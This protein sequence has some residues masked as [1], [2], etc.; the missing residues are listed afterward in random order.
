MSA[1]PE[2]AAATADPP[3]DLPAVT[4]PP[5]R[6]AGGHLAAVDVVRFLTIAGV[7]LVH[8]TSFAN[9]TTSVAA[10]GVLEV[11][12]ITR[13]V[14]LMLSAFVLSY[15][16]S[17]RPLP[18]RAFWR[19]RYPLIAIPYVV[20]SAIYFLTDGGVHASL[21]VVGTFFQDLLDGGAKFHLYFL[22]LTFQLY[23]IF[24]ALMAAFRRWPRALIPTLWASLAF[25][26]L[27][28]A[29][30][31][32]GWRPPILGVWLAHPGSWLPSY[33]MYVVGGVAA[34]R[35][36]DGLTAW[37]RGHYRILAAGFAAAVGLSVASYLLDQSFLGY[38]P[39][40]A[41]EV[42]QPANVLEA[43]AA[44][45]AEFAL[46]LWVAD[47]ASARRLA[48]LERASDVSFGLYLAHP[49]LLGAVLDVAGWV[50]LSAAMSGWPSGGVEAA[51]AFG[52]VPFLYSVTF[53]GVDIIRRTRYSLPLTG[54]RGPRPRPTPAP[55]P[56]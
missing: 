30:V 47:R 8:S 37:I 43:V 7:I 50:G 55:A 44:T 20:W 51:I 34:A 16:F 1:Q 39:I 29:G 31:H 32:Y 52:L 13:S 40:R 41:A 27:F 18:S 6:P 46:G 9:A 14:F 17:R 15:S 10:N 35:H 24:P 5:A 2:A 36:F 4:R 19:R 25:Q 49:L 48:F 42:F 22:L 21:P 45:A 28:T 23:L 11:F 56:A 53:V 3:A 38:A 33:T 26:L 54:R 12:H